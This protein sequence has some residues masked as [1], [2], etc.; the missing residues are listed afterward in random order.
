MNFLLSF[1]L[2]FYCQFF[3]F[4][5][6]C[7]KKKKKLKPLGR[8]VLCCLVF[9]LF[10]LQECM[11]QWVRN[12]EGKLV[13]VNFPKEPNSGLNLNTDQMEHLDGEQHSQYPVKRNPNAYRSMRDYRH[14]PWVSAPSCM[15]PPTNAPYGSTY[16]PS[17]G[18]HPNFSWKPIPP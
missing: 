18:K 6:H 8:I 1:F 2:V 14:P 16:N 12:S 10:L 15:L 9:A 3:F 17:W 13:K 4:S 5:F 7:K 11:F